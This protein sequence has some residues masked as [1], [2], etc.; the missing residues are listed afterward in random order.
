M[1]TTIINSVG[2]TRRL[3]DRIAGTVCATRVFVRSLQLYYVPYAVYVR[4]CVYMYIYILSRSIDC[5]YGLSSLI[6]F[7]GG[8]AERA[9]VRFLSDAEPRP[10]REQYARASPASLGSCDPC[11]PGFTG[12]C[13][14]VF[15]CAVCAHHEIASRSPSS[16]APDKRG[17]PGCTSKNQVSNGGNLSIVRQPKRGKKSTC[18][19][20]P[21]AAHN[22][23]TRMPALAI[24]TLISN[25]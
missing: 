23:E 14:C 6:R 17:N 5:C 4:A 21:F 19:S 22:P 15:A 8:T 9:S 1:I 13:R 2:N 11:P 3:H 24:R 12:A 7:S 20:P 16:S 18:R 25:T 10:R